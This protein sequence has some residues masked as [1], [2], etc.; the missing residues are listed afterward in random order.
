MTNEQILKKAI[1]KTRNG[2]YK[3][4]KHYRGHNPDDPVITAFIFT[5]DFA[6]AFFGEDILCTYC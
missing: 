3:E 1:E 2:G 5:H 6:K 4:A